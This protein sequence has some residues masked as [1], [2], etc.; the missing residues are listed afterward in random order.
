MKNIILLSIFLLTLNCSINKVSNVHGS[1]FLENKQSKIIINKTNKNDLR[2]LI[3]PPSSISKFE[4][5]WIYIERKKTNQS[6]M[7]L[8]VK[9]ISKN[10]ILII[11]FNKT[12]LVSEVN[13]LNLNNMNDLKL[14]EK[15]TFKK[16][17]KDNFVYDTLSILKEKINAP[18]RRNK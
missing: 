13:F 17:K 5:I 11:N 1:R 18:T 14:A 3:G 9:K 7:K 6:L 4:D 16:Y 12:G 2:K 10:N 8:G 15:K